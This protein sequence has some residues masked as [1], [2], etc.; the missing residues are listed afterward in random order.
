MIM[1]MDKADLSQKDSNVWN[2]PI[3]KSKQ[4]KTFLNKN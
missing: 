1:R 2:E 3:I 4:Q